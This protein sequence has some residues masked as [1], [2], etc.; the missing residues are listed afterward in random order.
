MTGNGQGP[1]DSAVALTLQSHV[2][3]SA[4]GMSEGGFPSPTRIRSQRESLKS[5]PSV[6]HAGR[7]IDEV[8]SL[9]VRKPVNTETPSHCVP[10]CCGY[11]G[12]GRPVPATDRG[13]G[14][15]ER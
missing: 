8:E 11:V 3:P 12:L 15:R 14:S 6:R 1:S 13:Q 9:P 10:S 4:K 5:L 2:G 7:A